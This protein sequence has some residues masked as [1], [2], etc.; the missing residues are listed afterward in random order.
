MIPFLHYR[1]MLINPVK[2]VERKMLCLLLQCIYRDCFRISDPH[3]IFPETT[4][5][6]IRKPYLA[7]RMHQ[8]SG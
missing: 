5:S 4:S 2:S 8:D 7:E 3:V 1:L 6:G